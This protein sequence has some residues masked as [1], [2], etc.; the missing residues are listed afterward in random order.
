[1]TNGWRVA[2][3][4]A[5]TLLLLACSAR[6]EWREVQT[7]DGVTASLPGRAQNVTRD[8][9]VGGQTVSMSMW[10]TGTGAAMFAIGSARLPAALAADA[11]GRGQAIAYFRDGLVRN[12]G[13]TVTSSAAA[14]LT[15]PPGGARKLLASEAVEAIGRPGP[16]GRKSRLAARFFIVDDQFFATQAVSAITPPE[17]PGCVVTNPP[18]GI[19]VSAS[20]DLRNLYAQFGNVLRAKCPGWQ[21]AVLCND[22]KL[23]GQMGIRLDTSFSTVNGGVSVR[24]GRGRVE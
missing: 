22:L 7:P 5:A 24:L 8:L 9:D 16:D 18:Y 23:L 12:I 4:A 10:S 21:V 19:R 1:M 2:L 17:G 3:V 14:A 6:F 11:A 20:H 13:G 15:L